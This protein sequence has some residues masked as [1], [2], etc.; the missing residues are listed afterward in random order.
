M[1]RFFNREA[2]L[3]LLIAS[4]AFLFAEGGCGSSD[5]DS[6]SSSSTTTTREMDT[7]SDDVR[8]LTP[9]LGTSGDLS[10]WSNGWNPDVQYT[11][12]DKLFD[13]DNGV[14]SV[15]NPVEQ[16]DDLVSTINDLE[17][18]WDE[19]GDV[20]NPD[21]PGAEITIDNTDQVV[22]VPFLNATVNADR[23]VTFNMPDENYTSTLAF[24]DGDTEE[25]LAARYE[26]A[27]QGE[28]GVFYAFRDADTGD[29]E[30]WAAMYTSDFQIILKWKGNTEDGWFSLSQHTNA[31]PPYDWYVMGGGQAQNADDQMA[32]MAKNGDT[33][34]GNDVYYLTL[35]QSQ[36]QNGTDP[37][38]IADASVTPPDPTATPVHQYITEGQERCFGFLGAYPTSASDLDWQ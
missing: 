17:A 8:T 35:T 9:Y 18:Y 16:L 34:N 20:T 22:T 26:L 30:I 37:G 29:I 27:D 6:S 31:S 15:W 3:V 12:L 36:L 38:T 4:L 24:T 7:Y 23:V 2:V 19:E 1:T 21:E 28:V 25:A 10:S 5:G 33:N 32:F 11:T 13:P 14:E